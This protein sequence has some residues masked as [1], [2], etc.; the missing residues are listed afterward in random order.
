MFLCARTEDLFVGVRSFKSRVFRASGMAR[1]WQVL[2]RE[3][4]AEADG[5]GIRAQTF[6]GEGENITKWTI[7]ADFFT[8]GAAAVSG[9]PTVAP[10]VAEACRQCNADM[11]SFDLGWEG[12]ICNRCYN[13]NKEGPMCNGS[14]GTALWKPEVWAGF[15]LCCHC[16]QYECKHCRHRLTVQEV[17]YAKACCSACYHSKEK[18]STGLCWACRT[19]LPAQ[20]N[21]SWCDACWQRWRSESG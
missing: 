6:V 4:N 19:P 7:V 15:G 13:Q 9:L 8:P 10:P 5:P 1:A 12:K 16:R 17:R 18:K 11:E 3:L 21:S 2:P 20:A 14:C